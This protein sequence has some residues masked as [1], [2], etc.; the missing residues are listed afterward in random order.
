MTYE[1]L[2]QERESGTTRQA[3]EVAIRTFRAYLIEK[4]LDP[5]LKYE[6]LYQFVHWLNKTIVD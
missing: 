4:G 6:F 1:T 3:T 2:L 5:C